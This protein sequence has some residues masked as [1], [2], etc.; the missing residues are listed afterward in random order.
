MHS[1]S[2]PA[3][4]CVDYFHTIKTVYWY[5]NKTHLAYVYDKMT[6]KHLKILM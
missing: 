5:A 1:G 6:I 4:Y 3:R 2:V